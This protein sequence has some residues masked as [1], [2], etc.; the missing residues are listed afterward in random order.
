M[1]SSLSG[2]YRW[3]RLIGYCIE[4]NWQDPRAAYTWSIA[5]KDMSVVVKFVSSHSGRR[6]H[7]VFLFNIHI[8]IYTHILTYLLSYLLNYLL[9]YLLTP[10][11]RVLLE[12]LTGFQLV[13]KFPTFYG[14]RRFITTFTS[15]R[16]LSVSWANSI[17]SI[18]PHPTSWRSNLLFFSHLRLGLPSCLFLSGFQTKTLHTPFLS[19]IRDTCPAITVLSILSPEKYWVRST[20]H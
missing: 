9:T 12:K 20:D 2:S 6:W 17:Q 11:S 14:T 5:E 7:L 16:H 10:W 3:K 4:R 1:I 15:A 13:K 18:T 19:H 8:Y